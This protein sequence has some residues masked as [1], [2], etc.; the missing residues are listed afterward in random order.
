M[1]VFL[2]S[3]SRTFFNQNNQSKLLLLQCESGDQSGD[4]IACA[5]YIMQD[6]YIQTIETGSLTH[7]VLIVQLSRKHGNFIGFQVNN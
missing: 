2:V 6:E 1:V 3:F 5:R 7:I 4:L